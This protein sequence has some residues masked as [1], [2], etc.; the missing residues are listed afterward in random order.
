MKA[1]KQ[2]LYLR[3]GHRSVSE[4][5]A[6]DGKGLIVEPVA[7]DDKLCL[8]HLHLFRHDKFI[9]DAGPLMLTEKEWKHIGK[10]MGWLKK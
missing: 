6:S 1:W 9:V 5:V 2:W 4:L 7:G 3:I 10:V 8:A